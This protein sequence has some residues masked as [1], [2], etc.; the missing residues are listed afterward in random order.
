MKR[1]LITLLLFGWIGVV[2]G[3]EQRSFKERNTVNLDI[4]SVEYIPRDQSKWITTIERKNIIYDRDSS[5]ISFETEIKRKPKPAYFTSLSSSITGLSSNVVSAN[6]KVDSDKIYI[7]PWVFKKNDKANAFFEQHDIYITMKDRNNYN[8]A[9]GSWQMGLV[10]LPLKWYMNSNLGNIN[11]SVNAMLNIGYKWGKSR[12]VKFPHE[13]DVRTYKT[14]Y[15]MNVLAGI[16]KLEF[17]KMNTSKSEMPIEKADVAAISLG[18]AFGIHYGDFTFI[19]TVGF[20]LPTAYR[21]DWNFNNIPW[22]GI[23]IGYNFLKFN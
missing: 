22:L 10:T 23:G 4:G 16:S 8:F 12:F 14:G 17:N 2:L 1:F 11:T 21:K 15:S 18:A 6:L 19:P 20:D 7:Y 9:Y 5:L 3:Q 13:K